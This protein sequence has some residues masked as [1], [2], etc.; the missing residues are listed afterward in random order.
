MAYWYYIVTWHGLLC[1][2]RTMLSMQS[3]DNYYY[4]QAGQEALEFI[5]R[6]DNTF[7]RFRRKVVHAL[8]EQTHSHGI[9]RHIY[10]PP[11]APGPVLFG[12]A[13]APALGCARRDSLG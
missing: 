5:F 11:T 6:F 3:L 4:E 9:C 8:Q 12:F 7:S 2:Y 13:S 10:T 1:Y